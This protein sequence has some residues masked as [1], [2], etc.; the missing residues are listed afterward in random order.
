VSV[1]ADAAVDHRLPA[2]A[3]DSTGGVWVFWLERAGSGWQVRY[4]RHDGVQWQLNTP[5]TLPLDGGQDPRVEDDLFLL[6]HPTSA[7]QRLW[8]FWSR[9]EPGG[10]PGQTRWTVAYRIK[11]GLDPNAADWS[12]VRLLPKAGAGS[13]HDREPAPTLAAGGNIE[14][15]W[16]ST[17]K[18]GWSIWSNTLNIGTLK[19]G[20]ALQVT[21]SPYSER[22]PLAIATSG[23]TLLAYRSN[24]SL[25]YSSAVYGATHT[26]DVRYAGAITV[27]TGNASKIALRGQFED[28]I[29][30]TYDAGEN[31]VRTNDDRIARDTVG[32][33]LSPNIADPDQI[34]A[35]ISRLSNVLSGFMPITERAVFITT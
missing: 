32:L 21:R 5:A 35:M 17:Q 20:T 30:Y 34:I 8:L 25:T 16:S 6:C 22:A 33:Y 13:Y 23:G 28:Y 18:G 10:L 12:P 1:L 3:L 7:T 2:A 27:D 11:Q 31:G 9:H 29:A 26:L 24:E 4:N 19:W 15:F 14:L